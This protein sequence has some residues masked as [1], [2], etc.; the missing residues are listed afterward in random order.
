MISEK[1]ARII[2]N[3][4]YNKLPENV[5]NKSKLCFIDFLAV[6]LR[7]SR[8]KSGKA[9]KNLF[10]NGESSTVLGFE[11]ANCTDA[12]FINGVFAHSLDLDDGH[13]FA[14]LHPGC[15]VIPASLALSEAYDKTGKEFI[16]SIVAGYQISI[17][18]GMIINPKHRNNGFHST[19]TCGTFGA[20]AAASKIMCLKPKDIINALGLAGTQAAGLLESDH[21][22]SMGKHLHAGKAAQAG[23][24]SAMLAENEFTGANLIIEGNEGF[25]KAMVSEN[26]YENYK[27]KADNLFDNK[28]YYI[29]DVYFKRYPVCRHLHSSIDAIIDI[30]KQMILEGTNTEDIQSIRIKT[31]EIASEHD[32]YNPQT[33]ESIRQSLPV[34]SAIYILNGELNL[35]NIELDHEI[36]SMA[37]K[38]SID[39]DNDMNKL[40]PW[41]RPSEVTVITKEKSYFCRVDL[42]QGEPENP[43]NQHEIMH[44]F[45][46]LNPKV[47][48]DVLNLINKL[49]SYKMNELME[50]L[51]NAFKS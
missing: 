17:I 26:H 51:N 41:K 18:L 16:S 34:T 7:G 42:P 11:K 36:I 5:I 32:D 40:Y 21:S 33:I 47:D 1:L 48:L 20:A 31:Y 45:H 2:V 9:V 15:S 35:E 27:I 28:K 19:G 30:H 46:N 12:P 14:Q 25:L 29:N 6:S 50:I 13:R 23:V 24:I 43:F 8:T 49:E 4:N 39:K 10:A 38:V 37:S 22:G 44:K 3:T